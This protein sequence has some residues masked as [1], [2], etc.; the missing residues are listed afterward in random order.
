MPTKRLMIWS[1]TSRDVLPDSDLRDA[2]TSTEMC[3]MLGFRATMDG[4]Q[5]PESPLA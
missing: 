1:F 4:L 3:K 5:E 2:P